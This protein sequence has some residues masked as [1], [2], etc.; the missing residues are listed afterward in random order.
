M[1]SPI[2]TVP[3]PQYSD[4]IVFVDESGDHG[5]KNIDPQYPVFVLVFCI[6]KKEYY[7]TVLVP[8]LISLKFDFFGHDQVILHE[9]DIRKDAK[10]FKFL[11]SRERKQAFID[12]LTSI[13]EP[14]EFDL[15]ACVIDKTK[16]TQTYQVA[17]NPYTLAL[18]FG[19]E[20]VFRLMIECGQDAKMTH[21]I[22][23]KRGK[24]EDDELELEFRRAC[25]G[26]NLFNRELPFEPIFVDKKTNSAG[27]QMAD[28]IARPI[29]LSE[30][31]PDQQNRA[32][33]AVKG[34]FR[35]DSSGCYKGRGLKCFP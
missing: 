17:K 26:Q 11:K 19:L 2:G 34:K 23:E 32:F 29:G 9:T 20:R 15:V 16:L 13:I 6:F 10:A 33:D 5:L 27:L 21:I 31:R 35:H 24:N 28:L 25:Q 22:I 30:M 1:I 4:Y 8:N 7:Q 14:A 3:E 18:H 12:S